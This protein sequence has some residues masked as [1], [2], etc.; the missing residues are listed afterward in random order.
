MSSDH[1]AL[2]AEAWA[3]VEQVAE[4]L[5]D[6]AVATCHVGISLAAECSRCRRV[7]RARQLLARRTRLLYPSTEF[8]QTPHPASVPRRERQSDR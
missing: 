8:D 4:P 5:A 3:I 1:S 2:D 6:L 7:L